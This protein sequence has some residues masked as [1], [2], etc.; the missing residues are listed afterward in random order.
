M[1]Q[2]AGRV[3]LLW[4]ARRIALAVAAGALGAL[5]LPP[6]GV[7]GTLF[8]SFTLLVW[9]MD[10][11]ASHP[12]SGWLARLRSAFFLGWLFGFG[13]FVA[14]L[15]WLGNALLVEADQFAWALPLAVFGLPAFLALFYGLATSL[16]SLLWSDGFGRL[17][18]LALGFGLTEW[19]R[20]FLMTGFPWNAIGY[21]AMPFPLMM[22]SAAVIGLFGVT[23][24]SILVFST[25]ALLGTRRGLPAGLVVASTLLVA[26]L[27]YGAYRLSTIDTAPDGTGTVVRLVQP[28]VD[29]SRKLENTD[30]VEIFEEHL[31]LSALPP[32]PGARRPDI[33][34]WPET[35]VPFILT[36][37]QDALA[38][39]AEVLQDGQILIAGAVRV[40]YAAAGT[41]PRFYN[42]VYMVDSNG[43]I[44]GA[45]DKV[46]LTPFG[47]YVPFEDW[48]RDW[49]I[50]SLV[51]L[52]GGFTAGAVPALL[53]LPGGTAFYPLIC[54]EAI[55]PGEIGADVSR[56]T[57][58]LNVTNDAWFGN[59]PGPYQHFQQARL[60]AV[61]TGLPLV[62]DANSGISAVVDP[63]GRIVAGLA[64]NER[65]VVDS[66]ISPKLVPKW[67][68]AARATHHW[69]ILFLM[70]LIALIARRGFKSPAN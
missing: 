29:Q 6:F 18:A 13:Y 38:R 3:M 61:E 27:G 64:F 21:G 31:S 47:E 43:Q 9:L 66:E 25:P 50:E 40:E 55:F 23:T 52:P 46:H 7:F 22:Q 42:S 45:S 70:F 69:L 59:T 28:V 34:V 17:A 11:L 14:G 32:Q 12:E 51:A 1:E 8:I 35:S 62:R 48:L 2:L 49:G 41:P 19:L 30:R 65:G 67:D 53:T 33:I 57:A 68:T 37:N 20:S 10:G 4:G 44:L 24:L 36:E 56:A 39:I 5:A 15:W 26:H 58:I 16:A 63:L 60:R 54:Y